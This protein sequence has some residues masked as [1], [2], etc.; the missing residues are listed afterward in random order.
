MISWS[1]GKDAAWALQKAREADGII[2]TGLFCTYDPA[3][4]KVPIH[5]APISLIKSQARAL[6]LPIDLI[7]LPAKASNKDYEKAINAYF[8]RLKL[9]DMD[10]VVYGDVSLKDV[11]DYKQNLTKQHSLEALFPLWNL[12]TDDLAISMVLA[13]IKAI[14]C[15]VDPQKV[16]PLLLGN[17]FDA[18]FLNALKPNVDPCGENGEFHTFVLYTEDFRFPVNL[19]QLGRSQSRGME[20]LEIFPYSRN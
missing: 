3:T 6:G 5:G 10:A 15:S 1:G 20:M 17:P 16:D 18:H 19:M 13:G 12:E 8:Q 14:V 2:V 4:E 9:R 11:R 7:P